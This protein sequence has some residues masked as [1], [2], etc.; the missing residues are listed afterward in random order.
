MD[1]LDPE[2]MEMLAMGWDY[3]PA[4]LGLDADDEVPGLLG[5]EGYEH[6]DWLGKG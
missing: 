5:G 2:V 4:P 3:L 1:Y 6:L